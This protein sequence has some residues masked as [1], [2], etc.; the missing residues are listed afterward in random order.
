MLTIIKKQFLFVIVSCLSVWRSV[1][2]SVK[3][4]LLCENM[5]SPTYGAQCAYKI[6]SHSKTD[7]LILRKKLEHF[8]N[9][10]NLGY[11]IYS[12]NIL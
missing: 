12:F 11:L 6:Q 10:Y 2:D 3:G 5:C 4:S 8:Q 9:L 7:P 1:N